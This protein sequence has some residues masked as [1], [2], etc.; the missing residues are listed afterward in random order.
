[1][2]I[3]YFGV[4]LPAFRLQMKHWPLTLLL[5]LDHQDLIS[6]LSSGT[7][8]QNEMNSRVLMSS[9]THFLKSECKSERYWLGYRQLTPLVT[10]LFLYKTR[11]EKDVEK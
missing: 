7:M 9:R 1:M 4:T 10:L 6:F 8:A 5:I 2:E 11:D 3:N